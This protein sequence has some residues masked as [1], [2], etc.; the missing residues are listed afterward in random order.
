MAVFSQATLLNYSLALHYLPL[1]QFKG[2]G[3]HDELQFLF[4]SR[5]NGMQQCQVGAFSDYLPERVG[6][7][8]HFWPSHLLEYPRVRWLVKSM[9][10][11]SKAAKCHQWFAWKR[12]RWLFDRN[13]QH[14]LPKNVTNLKISVVSLCNF[15]RCCILFQPMLRLKLH[16]I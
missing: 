6:F 10:S 2:W 9:Q 5:P 13:K 16:F 4:L 11:S 14:S 3:R 7:W 15:N 8:W 12:L 1:V